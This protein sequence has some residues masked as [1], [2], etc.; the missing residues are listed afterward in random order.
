MKK[1]S[2]ERE[3]GDG[4][5]TVRMYVMYVM[6]LNLK[7]TPLNNLCSLTLWRDGTLFYTYSIQSKEQNSKSSCKL[8]LSLGDTGGQ[9]L[10][11]LF[12]C[13]LRNGCHTTMV[14]QVEYIFFKL[15]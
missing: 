4:C 15:N 1:S 8:L 2:G 11:S 5:T 13:Y 14:F 9:M 10:S 6:P 7:I 3:S 12:F